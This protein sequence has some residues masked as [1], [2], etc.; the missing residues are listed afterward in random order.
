MLRTG[1]GDSDDIGL[2]KS[3]IADQS[4]KNL[5]G[6]DN[7]GNGI[8]KGVCHPGYRIGGPGT[9]GDQND[10]GLAAGSS[11]AIGRVDGYL[12][13]AAEDMSNIR[14]VELIVDPQDDTARVAED[15]LNT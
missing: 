13:M 8:H 1:T 11:I 9:R 2:L 4:G 3:I 10:P 12:L 7:D 6:K 15:H 5:P 14:I